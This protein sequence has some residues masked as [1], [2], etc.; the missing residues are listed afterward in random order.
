[1]KILLLQQPKSFSDYP[2]WIKEVQ[3]RFGRLEVM[4]FTSDN[5]AVHHRWPNTVI[6]EIVV[7]D[8]SSD[9]ATAKFFDIV[10]KFKPDRIISSSEEDVLRVAEAR[11]L[12]GIPGLQYELALRCR[13]KVT[14][15]QSALDAGLQVEILFRRSIVGRRLFSNLGGVQAPRVLRYCIRKMICLL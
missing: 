5:R 13:D 11:S 12:F 6:K 9:S 4:V 15:K 14:M 1:M 10:R 2:E 8:Y 3:E 7:S